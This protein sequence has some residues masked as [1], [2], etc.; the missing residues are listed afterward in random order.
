MVAPLRFATIFPI[1]K[2]SLQGSDN[3]AIRS[4]AEKEIIGE[5]VLTRY[6]NKNYRIDG[7]DWSASP[8]SVFTKSDGSQITYKSYYQVRILVEI[9]MM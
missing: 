9:Q 7:I 8:L 5:T 2:T 3:A 6:N 1:S 4:K